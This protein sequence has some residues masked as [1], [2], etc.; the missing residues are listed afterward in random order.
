VILPTA[1]DVE[2]W[3]RLDFAAMGFSSGDLDRLLAQA[4]AY[5]EQVTGRVPLTAVPDELAALAAQAVMMRVEQ[6]ASQ[7]Q[8]EMVES[9]TDEGGVISF[10]TPG[11]SET[12]ANPSQG[13]KVW[14]RVVNRWQALA[15]LLLL[16]MTEEKRDDWQAALNGTFAP[17]WE[18]T[19]MD[20]SGEG[21]MGPTGEWPG[22]GAL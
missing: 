19:E 14:S 21:P 12:R 16:L 3:S 15:D 22:W 2:A 7:A 10:S 13:G 4:V 8:E 6:L 17:E 1:A 20:W 5:V 9:A 18:V 11:Y